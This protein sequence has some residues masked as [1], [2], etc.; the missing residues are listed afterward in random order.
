MRPDKFKV[1]QKK[2][3][4]LLT[5]SFK[6]NRFDVLGVDVVIDEYG[7]SESG[8]VII[9]TYD[10]YANVD[11]AGPMDG[12]DSWS[13]RNSLDKVFE[14]SHRAVSAFSIEPEGKIVSDLTKDI[15]V[16]GP[17]ILN[18]NYAVDEKHE[19]LLSFKMTYPD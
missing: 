14:L 8:E 11:Y 6:E 16:D 15:N 2:L 12:F 13:F 19:F 17:A 3:A 5:Q 1:V 10:V 4:Y 7:L 9:Q 18:M